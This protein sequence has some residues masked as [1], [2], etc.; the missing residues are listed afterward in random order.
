MALSSI[1]NPVF[2][3]VDANFS[4]GPAEAGE[5]SNWWLDL[6]SIIIFGAAAGLSMGL[7]TGGLHLVYVAT[8]IPLLL[9]ASLAI[10]LPS[11]QVLGRFAGCS[12]DLVSTSQLALATIART[13]IVAGSLAPV[14]AYFALTLP[15]ASASAYRAVVLSQV[16]TFA[17]AGSI[18]VAT[19][20]SR[21]GE[22]LPD[23]GKR[24][25]LILLWL[26][27][28]SFVGAQVT[29]LLRPLLGTPGLPV[30][31]F[32]SYGERLGLESNFYTS[33]YRLLLNLL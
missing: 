26:A 30:E 28:Y 24:R 12:L 1:P 21:L 17:V 29:W 15:Q 8:K 16:F 7:Y 22:L 3:L 18:G 20:S 13:A 33:V 32:R 19:L 23:K 25:R 5:S 9:L 6:F 27:I 10:V 11:M 2:R 14:T 4:A 31:Y